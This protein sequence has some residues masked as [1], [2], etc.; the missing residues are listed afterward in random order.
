[1]TNP[2]FETSLGRR[3]TTTTV[4]QGSTLVIFTLLFF[5]YFIIKSRK[6][7]FTPGNGF[8]SLSNETDAVGKTYEDREWDN[9]PNGVLNPLLHSQALSHYAVHNQFF[10]REMLKLSPGKK[11]VLIVGV[12]HGADLFNYA[13]QNWRVIAFEPMPEAYAKVALRIKK[14]PHWDVE[15]HNLA[16]GNETSQISIGYGG[17]MASVKVVRIDDMVNEEISI[18]SA[19]VQ[20]NELGVLQ[21]AK[22]IIEQS[23]M[24]IWFEVIACNER[25]LKLMELLD[26]DFVLFD[27]V[28]VTKKKTDNSMGYRKRNNFLFDPNRPSSFLKF[29]D[30]LC[31]NTEDGSSY[32][33][34]DILAVRRSLA[35]QL[36]PSLSNLAKRGCSMSEVTCTLR[37]LD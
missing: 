1:M 20:G 10:Q 21:G 16:A 3:K 17:A 12:D 37:S 28:P 33:Q 22:R 8:F 11:T 9:F 30:W 32:I 31:A 7:S 36:L 14:N 23:V 4:I 27:F 29:N 13:E 34:T 18:I 6:T 19:D 24:I 25:S 26:A 35:S 2:S 15:F 5:C